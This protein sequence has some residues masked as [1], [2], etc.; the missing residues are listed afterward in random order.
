MQAVHHPRNGKKETRVRVQVGEDAGF[1]IPVSESQ[2]FVNWLCLTLNRAQG[3]DE[4]A[5]RMQKAEDDKPST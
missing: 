5:L 3:I 2:S 1:D 4:S